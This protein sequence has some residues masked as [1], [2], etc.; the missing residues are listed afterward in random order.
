ML[1]ALS[2]AACGGPSTD[3]SLDELP[4]PIPLSELAEADAHPRAIL[5]RT[6]TFVSDGYEI[7]FDRGGDLAV[8]LPAHTTQDFWVRTDATG[9]V[10]ELLMHLYEPGGPTLVVAHADG[11]EAWLEVK[12]TGRRTDSWAAGPLPPGSYLEAVLA[13]MIDNERTAIAEMIASGVWERT[14]TPQGIV[15]Q[16]PGPCNHGQY[17]VPSVRQLHLT[18]DES[19]AVEETCVT[20]AAGETVTLASERIRSYSL[21]ADVWNEVLET[22]DLGD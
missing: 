9:V 6:E 22:A 19:A 12:T 11:R 7:S 3:G 10:V 5:L 15:Y 13:T 21:P 17:A 1:C 14:S 2:I 4:P 18:P 8:S 20:Q 16:R